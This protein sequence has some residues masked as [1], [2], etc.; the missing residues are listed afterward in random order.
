MLGLSESSYF[1]KRSRYR[2]FR[3]GEPWAFR[4]S[5]TYAEVH[6]IGSKFISD[7]FE[8]A[9]FKSKNSFF[10]ISVQKYQNKAFM[11]SNSKYS[12]FHMKLLFRVFLFFFKNCIQNEILTQVIKL[13]QYIQINILAFKHSSLYLYK[14]L[15]IFLL[16]YS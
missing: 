3:K 10:Q 7:K 11:V 1:T 15:F 12:L 8:G 9:D 6:Y 2:T 13:T 4:K 16:S 14:F 5:R